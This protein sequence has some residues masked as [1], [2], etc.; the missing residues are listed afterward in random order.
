MN[1]LFSSLLFALLTAVLPSQAVY[2]NWAGTY[3]AFN[4]N[5]CSAGVGSQNIS[6]ACNV[7]SASYTL[8][9]QTIG[10]ITL[11]STMQFGTNSVFGPPS[12]SYIPLFI[13]EAFTIPSYQCLPTLTATVV[14]GGWP[15][16]DRLW[17]SNPVTT[18]PSFG[19]TYTVAGAQYDFWYFDIVLPSSTAYLGTWIAGQ[20][21]R[22]DSAGNL[23]FSR[24]LDG[25]VL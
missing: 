21:M 15:G 6:L 24:R 1:A 8:C 4:Q 18:W 2:T 19:F 22:F 7:A 5:T 10:G 16:C 11:G 25:L 14:P 17:I 12:G 13:L 3:L 20:A 23:Y 9:G